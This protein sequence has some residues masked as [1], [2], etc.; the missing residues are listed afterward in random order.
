MRQLIQALE[1]LSERSNVVLVTGEAG[2]GKTRLVEELTGWAREQG[3]TVCVG[4]CIDLGA[5]LWPLAPWREIMAGL[6]DELGDADLADL[7][8]PAG[9][10]LLRL[11]QDRH[12]HGAGQS[13]VSADRLAELVVGLFTRL[14]RRGRLLVVIEDLHWADD[15]T[16][17]L[18]GALAR[19]GRLANT[20]LVGTFRADELHRRHPL[21][22]VIAEIERH[23]PCSRV[24]VAAL[25]PDSTVQLVTAI[26]AGDLEPG[27][28]QQIVIRSGGNPFFIEELVAAARLGIT[29]LPATLRDTVLARTVSLD[30]TSGQVLAVIAAADAT[31][32]D[33]VADATGL[34][35]ER[36]RDVL[37]ELFS[38]SLLVGDGAEVRFRHALAREVIE[39]DLLPGERARIHA[40][41][42]AS[43]ER[44]RPARPGAVARHW[45]AAHDVRRA[46][47]ASIVAGRQAL[48]EG[49]AA[50]AEE[51]FGRALDLWDRVGDPQTLT[52]T[53]HAELLRETAIRGSARTA[54]GAGDRPRSTRRR[55]AGRCR[56]ARS[57]TCV[58]PPPRPLPERRPVRRV[59]SAVQ[60]ALELIPASPPS[61]L[62]AIALANAAMDSGYAERLDD[63][64]LFA[65]RAVI[66]AEEV[67]DR[68]ALIHAYYALWGR[69]NDA[70]E[71]EA[72]LAI[73]ETNLHR[74][75]ATT[76]PE[77]TLMALNC[78]YHSMW[79][80]GHVA[81]AVGTARRGVELA[82]G[83]GLGGPHGAAMATYWLES[84]T[85]IG[86]WREAERVAA[87]LRDLTEDPAEDGLL[88]AT[89]GV[90]FIHQGRLDDARPLVEQARAKWH[91]TAWSDSLDF[92]VVP[93]VLFDAAE[94]RVDQAAIPLL[95]T[96]LQ[97]PHDSSSPK[98]RSLARR[99][100][101]A[102]QLVAV[103]IG[104][105]A[106]RIIAN[107]HDRPR[108]SSSAECETATR[109]LGHIDHLA[110]LGRSS[111][112]T[113]A[114][115][116]RAHAEFS[117]LRGEPDLE[118]WS[119]TVAAFFELGCRY[120]EAC[121][122]LHLAESL[123]AGIEGRS[124]AART[125]ARDELIAAG[126]I[127]N[128]LP[129]PPLVLA[130]DDLARRA[131]VAL[132]PPGTADDEPLTATTFGLTPHE[133]D[134]LDLLAAGKSNGQ[135]A[136]ALFISTKTASVHVSNIL[137]KL[138]VANRVE[139]AAFHT[140]VTRMSVGTADPNAQAL[141]PADVRSR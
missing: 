87:D 29:R 130:I 113:H 47:G 83:S 26:T 84:L 43:L 9:D 99:D 21:R 118:G 28:V 12:E 131:A 126:A 25:D 20:L 82:R 65:R 72:A 68:D 86:R 100:E 124:A 63:A 24:E 5:Q 44:G 70:D 129:A 108:V 32:I 15:T 7:L 75:D 16:Q 60:R 98:L 133:R 104:L 13:S 120:E 27:V 55:G 46:L 128:E 41:L 71:H 36:L 137:R 59:A 88:A 95:E 90:T 1:D 40:A 132:H 18:F 58:A 116:V 77:L 50:E 54:R 62:L 11:V 51:H 19:T 114:H 94:G 110:P 2:S 134:V 93:L 136:D 69:T 57:G 107:R 37:D 97:H 17:I 92:L 89:L 52:G 78:Q 3:L 6:I 49:A 91:Q 76:A 14:A 139:A 106:D 8:G 39:D 103:G 64:A 121:A 22:P 4:R 85:T 81:A 109:W 53:E 102:A 125:A 61:A 105:L 48:R 56:R 80:V 135:I 140:R 111:K 34:E 23:A 42:A 10:V 66:V 117:R 74:C 115:R 141:P 101:G 123:L 35:E 31:T 30:G 67:G 138:N 119:A 73:A 45:A 38:R 96:Q 127:A 122:R 79:A 33:V 112:L